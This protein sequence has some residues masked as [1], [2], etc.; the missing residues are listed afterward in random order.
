[1]NVLSAWLDLS[2]ELFPSEI[3]QFAC[4]LTFVATSNLSDSRDVVLY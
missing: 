1:M 2:Y 3:E 4:S